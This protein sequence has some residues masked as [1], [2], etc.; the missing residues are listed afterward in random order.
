[1][2]TAY[3]YKKICIPLPELGTAFA[4][5]GSEDDKPAPSGETHPIFG[6]IKALKERGRKDEALQAALN[7]LDDDGLDN[8]TWEKVLDET[9]ELVVELAPALLASEKVRLFK[10]L[11]RYLDQDE[12]HSLV[13]RVYPDL[14]YDAV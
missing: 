9:V 11:S 12:Q 6:N 10:R 1:M 4:A 8:D 5:S 13:Q 14:H 3:K 2:A 7:A